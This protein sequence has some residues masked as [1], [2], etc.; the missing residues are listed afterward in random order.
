MI[1]D[2]QSDES[3]RINANLRYVLR[4]KRTA[5]FIRAVGTPAAAA[6]DTTAAVKDKPST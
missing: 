1:A 2:Y 5:D 6:A 3:D 4:V